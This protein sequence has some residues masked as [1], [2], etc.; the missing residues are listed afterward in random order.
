MKSIR[1]IKSS[2]QWRLIQFP[3]I[4]THPMLNRKLNHYRKIFLIWNKYTKKRIF[5]S[6]NPNKFSKS[7]NKKEIRHV[8]PHTLQWFKRK[9]RK[10]DLNKFPWILKLIRQ[11]PLLIRKIPEAWILEDNQV[12][13]SILEEKVL[14]RS[15]LKDK[16]R[17]KN[18]GNMPRSCKVKS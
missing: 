2:S 3:W 11:V 6:L 16:T 12:S 17:F 1:K 5:T 9:R 14:L 13:Y 8:R 18:M 15:K 10:T 4:R 7:R